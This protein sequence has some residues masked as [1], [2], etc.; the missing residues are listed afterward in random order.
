MHAGGATVQAQTDKPCIPSGATPG[1]PAR[2]MTTRHKDRRRIV[3]PSLYK[4]SHF[5]APYFHALSPKGGTGPRMMH[6]EPIILQGENQA[7]TSNLP[8]PRAISALRGRGS[9]SLSP[10]LSRKPR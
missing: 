9:F 2:K 3:V 4:S 5:P 8:K 6:I 1:N 7:I 10:P